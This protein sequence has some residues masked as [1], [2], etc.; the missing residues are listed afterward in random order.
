MVTAVQDAVPITPERKATKRQCSIASVTLSEPHP[1]RGI[2]SMIGTHAP[3][4][5][6]IH[7]NGPNPAYT[8]STRTPRSKMDDAPLPARFPACARGHGS[9]D[10]SKKVRRTP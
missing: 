9:S 1:V 2:N 8:S 5:T 4:P 7:L 3:V 6:S 10:K